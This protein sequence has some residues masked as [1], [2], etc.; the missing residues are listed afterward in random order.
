M[1][2]YINILCSL[3]IPACNASAIVKGNYERNEEEELVN[4]IDAL[5]A[6]EE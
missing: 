3:G 4:L 6:K 1:D 2:Y 5:E